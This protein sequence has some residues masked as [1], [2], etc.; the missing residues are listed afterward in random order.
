MLTTALALAACSPNSADSRSGARVTGQQ[1]NVSDEPFEPLSFELNLDQRKVSLGEQLFGDTRLSDDNTVACTSCHIFSD[2]G[3]NG[4]PRSRLPDRAE[5]A[6]NVPTIF[7]VAGNFRFLWDGRSDTLEDTM[8]VPVGSPAALRTS[9]PALLEKLNAIDEYCSAFG[10]IYDDGVTATNVRDAIATYERSLSTP[11]ARFD[12]YLRGE[13]DALSEEERSGYALFNEYGCVS[14]HQGR[15]IGGNMYQKLG[16]MDD[17]FANRDDIAAADLGRFGVTKRES[18]RH[19]F[20]VPSL[21][22]A[23]KTAPYLHDGSAPTLEVIIG[24]MAR[25]Q[26]GRHLTSEQTAQ[27]A[28]FLETLTGEY[29][30]KSL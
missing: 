27:I 29:R 10:A 26:L 13:K 22:N 1:F 18:D 9:W 17:Y 3:A 28:A 16:I 21:R 15:N 12:L 23:A 25:Y 6:V 30:G 24:V 7:N 5:G 20:R 4:L 2:G 8:N 11:G 19:V 14:C